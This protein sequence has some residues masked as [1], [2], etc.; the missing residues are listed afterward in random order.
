MKPFSKKAT[1]L[2]PLILTILAAS[3]LF[4]AIT[5]AAEA[6]DEAP[7]ETPITTSTITPTV[8]VTETI[9]TV[10]AIAVTMTPT[11]EPVTPVPTEIPVT[12]EPTEI[13]ATPTAVPTVTSVPTVATP[14]YGGDLY[15]ADSREFPA[16][17]MG[18]MLRSFSPEGDIDYVHYRAKAGQTEIRTGNLGGAAD[19][20]LEIYNSA[21]T[22][23]A[24]DDDSGSG[25]ASAIWL[26]LD[27]EETIL[28]VVSNKSLGYGPLVT[29]DLQ[30]I[31]QAEFTPTPT[32]PPATATPI[33]P[34]ATP[35]PATAT[36][37]PTVTPVPTV[38][39]PV[40]VIQQPRGPLPTATPHIEYLLRVEVFTDDDN[41]GVLDV[42][43][44]IQGVEIDIR[45][46]DLNYETGGPTT[47]G[48]L[49]I[50]IICPDDTHDVSQLEISIP[51]LQQTQIV[52]MSNVGHT[53]VVQFPLNAPLLPVQ[54]P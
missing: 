8:T 54:M 52:D 46:L 39:T 38:A 17:Y 49:V 35:I 20:Y 18:S 10:T 4:L 22:L 44:G 12:P 32:L 28:I 25:L 26:M 16:A 33:Q 23:I 31:P 7:T 47:N 37:V 14:D 30:I 3:L 1:T 53:A 34:T 13:P 9:P 50:P 24:R 48:V 43:E 21:G 5:N 45:T 15:E 51:Y 36:A 2:I 29:Y 41:D 27:A 19:T 11:I 42:G 40:A 6:E